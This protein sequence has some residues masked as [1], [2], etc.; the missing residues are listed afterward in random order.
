MIEFEKFAAD[1]EKRQ[2]AELAALVEG[3]T[4]EQIHEARLVAEEWADSE[5]QRRAWSAPVAA[6]YGDL[7]CFFIKADLMDFNEEPDDVRYLRPL[8]RTVA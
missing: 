8:L 3:W 1:A 7:W 5:R 2:A 6:R 4:Q